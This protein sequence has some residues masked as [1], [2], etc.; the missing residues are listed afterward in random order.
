MT[1]NASF[2]GSIPQVYDR[3]LGPVIFEPYARDLARRVETK[4]GLCVLETACGTGIVTRRLLQ[5][6]PADAHLVSTDLNGAMIAH[7]RSMTP[8]DARLEWREAD[9]Q[10][11]PFPDASFDAL[12]CQF[13]LMFF[14]DRLAGL[15]EARRVLRRGG[16]L[17]FN[18]WDAL[19]ANDFGRIAHET[20]TSYFPKDPP[21]FYL[22][23]FGWHDTRDV[24]ATV[25]RAGF[26]GIAIET[27]ECDAVSESAH[28][29]ATGLV[30]GNPVETMILE[31]GADPQ[32]ILAAVERKLSEAWG[33][34]PCRGKM[35]AHVLSAKA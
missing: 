34:A 3:H 4:P 20:I 18:V 30:R 2:V 8:A 21:Q 11:L 23:P 25:E 5:K 12:V 22:T 10:Q 7:A 13:G 14:P 16:Q 6:L 28:S 35:R 17:L 31:R 24:R 29:F 1:T 32:P 9:A 33:S 15:R 26:G 19:A 27:V